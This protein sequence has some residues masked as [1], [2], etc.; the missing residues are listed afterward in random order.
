[1]VIVQ[2]NA[3]YELSSTGRTTQ[4]MHEYLLAKGYDSYVFCPQVDRPEKKI[5]RIG[6]YL[7]Q[8]IHGL[9]SLL[10][11]R[12]G[13]YSRIATKRMLKKWDKIKPDIVVLRNL[14]ANYINLPMVFEYLAKKDIATV[15]VLHD[16][17]SMTGHCCHYIVDNCRKWQ[18][19]CNHC[20]I[21]HKY[22]KSLIFDKSRSCFKSKEKGWQ[23]I[24]RLAVIGVS[25]W[26]RDEAKKSPMFKNALLIE[27]IYNWVDV[28]CFHP[29]DTFLLRRK[30]HVSSDD[31]IVLGVAQHWTKDKGLF[32]FLSIAH[33]LPDC[34]FVMIGEM[35]GYTQQ[36]PENV[37]SVGIINDFSELSLYY[38]MANVFLNFSV[39]ET[40]GKVMAEA[41]AAGC[42]IICN[43]TTALPELC[44][45]GCGFVMENGAWEKAYDFINVIRKNDKATYTKNCRGFAV[46]NFEK[47]KGLSKY[48]G[49]FKQLVN[50]ANGNTGFRAKYT[51]T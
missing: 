4:E 36:C 41:L 3:V 10:F 34:K 33:K 2:V 39:V 14:H 11:G 35:G 49:L 28:D 40:F 1:M 23:S 32:K 22:N 17:F 27:R 44:G 50:D 43:N 26:A 7:D 31:F 25:N 5:Y 30:L 24:P 6:N 16:F 12:Q 15:N 19:E 29:K 18:S 20:P 45:D 8:K 38:S 9:F 46:S 47:I 37:I 48:E 13:E 42:P 21:L 51:S